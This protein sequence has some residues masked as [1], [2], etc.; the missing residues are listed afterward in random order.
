VAE[1]LA[2]G[3]FPHPRDLQQFRGDLA[4]GPPRAMKSNRKTVGFIA[5]LL[6]QV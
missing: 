1:E 3:F 4:F 6:D 2:G 5:D